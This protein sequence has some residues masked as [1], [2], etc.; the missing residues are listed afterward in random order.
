[1]VGEIVSMKASGLTKVITYKSP[2]N[3]EGYE[4][5]EEEYEGK[6]IEAISAD[7]Y[8]DNGKEKKFAQKERRSFR[9]WIK[10]RKTTD[11]CFNEKGNVSRRIDINASYIKDIFSIP[12]NQDVVIR[13][14]NIARKTKAVLV[15]VDGMVDKTTI[16]QFI[17]PQLMESG[18]FADFSGNDIMKYIIDNVLS[19]TQLTKMSDYNRIIDQI[20]NGL[21]ALFIDGCSEALL[22]ETRGFE[23]RNI[24]KPVTE[25]VVRGSQEAFTENLR[26]NITL[27]RRIIK[28]QKLITEILPV[29]K[30]NR[31]N[32]AILYIEGIT[33]PNI[34]KE[35]RR[36]I[37]NIDIDFVEGNG[38]LEQLVEEKP[39]MIFPQVVSTERPD[40]ASS[41]L[42]EGQVVIIA[43]GCPFA[44]AAPTSFFRLFHSSEDASL[45][46]QYG[47]FLRLIRLVGVVSALLLPGLYV[48]LS[49]YH[50]EL[51]PTPLLQSIIRTRANVP[52]P[53]IVEL[54][55]MEI[56][57]ELIREAGVR[58]PGVIGQTLGI[59]GALILGQVAVAAGIASSMLIVIVA[60][61]GL[62]SFTIPNFP[63]AISIRILRYFIIIAGAIAG[64]YGVFLA[65]SLI[66]ALGCNMKSFG[67]P[68]FA[69]I[70]PK[71][72]ANPDVI[73]RQQIDNQ[74]MRSDAFNAPN[75]KKSGKTAR[76]WAKHGG[77]NT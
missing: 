15:F 30:A 49:L 48:A 55:L 28:N 61:T 44:M 70:A 59:V 51:V 11:D 75:R 12:Q 29:G 77:N 8:I 31:V 18:H 76:K 53:T 3:E 72:K 58:I 32:S 9:F 14:F 16:N 7:E 6:E 5:L 62:G 23:K 34:V 22:I 57:F 60:I 43:E 25:Q 69:P 54:L 36:R 68:F 66:L 67:V 1:M 35:V 33:N 21:S 71:T 46:W 39:F 27:L 4:L 19:I 10:K 41:F 13:E 45:R 50:I 73:I 74:E 65:L 2:A 52:F 26:T 20:L 56:S 63:M 47:T 38:M 42:M 64:F 40:R 37:K 17:L 24:D